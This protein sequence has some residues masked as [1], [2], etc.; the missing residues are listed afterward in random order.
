[1]R[2]S[3]RLVLA[4]VAVAAVAVGTAALVVGLTTAS[5]FERFASDVRH[6]EAEHTADRLAAA[7]ERTGDLRKASREVFPRGQ[8]RGLPLAVVDAEGDLVWGPGGIR[9]RVAIAAWPA[10]PLVVAGREIG[11]LHMPQALGPAG[12]LP[13]GSDARAVL[14]RAFINE[15]VRSLLIGL[16]I[17]VGV[18]LVVG[19]VIAAGI[20]RPLRRLTAAARG[21][22]AG[23]LRARSGLAGRDELATVGAAFD[24]MAASLQAQEAA[25]RNLFADIAHEL[26]TPVTVIEGNLQAMLDGVY[27]RSDETLRSTLD[28]AEGLH[29]L[30]EDI[31]DLSLADVGKLDLSLEQVALGRVLDDATSAMRSQAQ[32]K[33][34]ALEAAPAAGQAL[35]DE[36]RLRQILANL[37][38]NAVRHTPSGGSIAIRSGAVDEGTCWIEV[39]DTGEGIPAE[40][41]PHIFDRFY[42]G[43]D[44]SGRKTRG[45][46]L[47]L[48]IARAL[49]EA[50]DGQLTARST[51]GEGSTFRIELAAP[52][53]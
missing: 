45:S 21:V 7:Y 14:E 34:V 22:A 40:D 6:H 2:L 46:G 42:R 50:M 19:V 33:G 8:P 29:R 30:V 53:P 51:P 44:A 36:A 41:L 43:T 18:A 13:I 31:R 38:D 27:D 24:D 16:A 47:G 11:Q 23:D 12:P 25:R 1:M 32:A 28:R 9:S 17:A 15:T 10:T 39:A 37:L 52:S 35:A 3:L 49:V 20:T 48:A 4:F 5:R 26:R